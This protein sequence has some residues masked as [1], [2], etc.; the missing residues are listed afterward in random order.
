VIC[1]GG[2]AYKFVP[3]FGTACVELAVDGH[4]AHGLKRFA[5]ANHP[6]ELELSS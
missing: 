4:S 6:A 1:A 3:L 5:L 2:W